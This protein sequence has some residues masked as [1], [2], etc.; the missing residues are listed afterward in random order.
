MLYTRTACTPRFRA[1]RNMTR[2]GVMPA[3]HERWKGLTGGE[4]Q[5]LSES[6]GFGVHEELANSCIQALTNA[7]CDQ[8]HRPASFLGHELALQH[9]S[10]HVDA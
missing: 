5:S 9:I 3:V 2:I 6:I 10:A 7:G 8:Q 1:S 4:K